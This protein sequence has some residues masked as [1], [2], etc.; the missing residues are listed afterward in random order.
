MA[1]FFSGKFD[2][3]YNN[4]ILLLPWQLEGYNKC[5]VD[6]RHVSYVYHV[7]S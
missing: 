5:K 7:I 4:I 3:M 2:Q 1:F 6:N